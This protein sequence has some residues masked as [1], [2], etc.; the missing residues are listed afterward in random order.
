MKVG[1]KNNKGLDA[2]A[3]A[4]DYGKPEVAELIRRAK[5]NL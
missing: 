1:A 4:V 5:S 2:H 3:L